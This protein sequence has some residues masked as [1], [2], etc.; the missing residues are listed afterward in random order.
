MVALFKARAADLERTSRPRCR[1]PLAT[2]LYSPGPATRRS[3][4]LVP[5]P[6]RPRARSHRT[7]PGPLRAGHKWRMGECI[8]RRSGASLGHIEADLLVGCDGVH[9]VVRRAQYPD[10]GPPKWNGITMWRGVT[11]AASLLSGRT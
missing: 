4:P 3:S 1:V 9:S 2:A 10:E 5:R 8:E 11:E 7:P 6:T